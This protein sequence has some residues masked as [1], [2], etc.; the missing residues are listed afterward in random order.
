MGIVVVAPFVEAGAR[1]LAMTLGV[2]NHAEAVVVSHQ[3]PRRRT[4]YEVAPP[5]HAPTVA[6]G[7]DST[8]QWP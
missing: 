6:R 5:P 4:S 8:A 3:A 2:I 7:E 1:R